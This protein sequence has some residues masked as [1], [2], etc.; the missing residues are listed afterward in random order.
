MIGWQYYNHAIV[1]TCAPHEDAGYVDAKALFK[2]YGGVL[3]RY[4]SDFDC[5]TETGWWYIIKDTP[6]DID[7]LKS[8]RRYVIKQGEKNFD[9][10]VIDPEEYAEE[11]FSVAERAFSAYPEKYRPQLDKQRF[12][13]EIVCRK[14]ESHR[15]YGAFLRSNGALCGY[16]IL[17]VNK[18][19]GLEV[20]K[21]DPAFECL[22]VNAALVYKVLRDY[23]QEIKAGKYITNG[24]RNILHETAFDDYLIKYF[25]F[26]KAYCNLHIIYRSKYKPIITIAYVMRKIFRKLD[27]IGIVHKLNGILKMEEIVRK[28]NKR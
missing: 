9:V 19:Y 27:G 13:D 4:T 3:I 16:T 23:E 11:I 21:T 5:K 20:Q 1:P 17:S 14:H 15:I 6:F 2:K 12:I 26:R 8:K 7:T 18:M 10:K 22:Q 28:Q 24:T 25:G